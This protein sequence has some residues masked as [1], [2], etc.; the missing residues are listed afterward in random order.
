MYI[1]IY[2]YIHTHTHTHT[3]G[4]IY[5][6]TYIHTCMHMSRCMYKT[7]E[8]KREPFIMPANTGNEYLE[9]FEFVMT[10]IP[11]ERI[12][13]AQRSRI[14][15]Q[16]RSQRRNEEA[17]AKGYACMYGFVTWKK[18]LRTCMHVSTSTCVCVSSAHIR[19]HTYIHTHMHT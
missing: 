4:C 19:I 17:L 15:L 16:E 5:I 2:T 6:H 10:Q 12:E 8:A 14:F 3:H 1:Y 9:S 11:R 13:E 7:F 18:V